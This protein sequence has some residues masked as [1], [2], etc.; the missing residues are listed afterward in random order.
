MEQYER[1]ENPSFDLG[2]LLQYIRAG[3]LVLF[4]LSCLLLCVVP[5]YVQQGPW[6][7]DAWE[8]AKPYVPVSAEDTLDYFN[9]VYPYLP[10]D[11]KVPE[12]LIA[13][14]EQIGLAEY[15]IQAAVAAAK[16]TGIQREHILAIYVN[17]PW[18]RV[19]GDSFVTM[20]AIGRT[21]GE[22]G[23]HN[24]IIICPEVTPTP[25]PEESV[26]DPD[27]PEDEKE[28]ICVEINP[29]YKAIKALYPDGGSTWLYQVLNTA[30]EWVAPLGTV[31]I[32]EFEPD[33]LWYIAT[34]FL[35]NLKLRIAGYQDDNILV[36]VDGLPV[37][38]GVETPPVP[39]P[40]VPDGY[41]VHPYPGATI[42]GYRFGDPVYEGGKLIRAHHP[43]VDLGKAGGGPV[44]AACNGRVTY[45]GW[46][47]SAS[48]W[49]SGIVV[50]IE[51]SPPVT[52]PTPICTLYGHG[53][54]GTLKVKKGDSVG[55]GDWLFMAGNTGYS[56]GVHLHFD[57]RVGG[58]G[59]FCN[60]SVDPMHYI[61]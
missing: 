40:I 54:E 1:D 16:R 13:R 57:V 58:G 61:R 49:I 12:S 36:M 47:D 37:I 5:Y 10:G 18:M 15:D 27:D 17:A 41:F 26:D 59:P 60:Q 52:D 51:C 39:Y 56:F 8:V 55:A 30:G 38:V 34:I 7:D 43:G 9:G 33:E 3:C 28:S 35:E 50:A 31:A 45:A 21:L 19:S 44:V 29:K 22:E 6:L 46:M 24:P 14:A 4:L 20:Y 2:S 48:L 42:S 32:E 25:V 23:Y 53:A 11:V